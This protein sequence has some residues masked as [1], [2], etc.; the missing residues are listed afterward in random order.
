MSWLKQV[1]SLSR[2]VTAGNCALINFVMQVLM[3]EG[4]LSI[5]L[6]QLP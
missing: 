4:W 1:F 6:Y 3:V 2:S 5:G